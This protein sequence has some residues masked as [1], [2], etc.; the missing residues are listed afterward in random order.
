M[1]DVPP[2]R[3]L[4]VDDVPDIADTAVL[5]LQL[6]GFEARACYDPLEALRIIPAFRPSVCMLDLNM[7]GMNGDQLAVRIREHSSSPWPVLIAVT[8]MSDSENAARIASAG[9]DLHL[10]KP[11]DP[12]KLVK[13]VDALWQAWEAICAGSMRAA[14]ALG[15]V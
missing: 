10:V 4:Y 7:P 2:L 13:V 15:R 14:D 8:A 11:V 3:V 12:N 5:L 6:V 9:F 1:D